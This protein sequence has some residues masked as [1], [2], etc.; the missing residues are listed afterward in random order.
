EGINKLFH[1]YLYQNEEAS[2]KRC[3]NI[4]LSLSGTMTEKLKK[5]SY[6]IPGGYVLFSQDLED[7]VKKYKIQANKGVKELSLILQALLHLPDCLLPEE[8][9]KAVLLAQEINTMEQ[10]QRQLEEKMEAERRSNEERMRQMREKMDEEMRLQREEA[11]RAMD[12]KL[13]EQAALL[14]KGFQEKADRMSEE[15]EDFRRKNKNAEKESQKL[16]EKM[17]ANMN[18]RH[19]E[20]MNL[21]KRQHS[22]QMEAI[23]SMPKPSSDS[24]ALVLRLLL[25]GLSSIT[26]G[27]RP[28]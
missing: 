4:L 9:E 24:S 11:E 16:F 6:A 15:M 7:I 18:K 1:G 27:S 5:G 13:R 21:M 3:E 20:T 8:R 12:S 22:E 10:K 2:R 23:M 26:G 17:I 19:A 25:I 14:D 28:C